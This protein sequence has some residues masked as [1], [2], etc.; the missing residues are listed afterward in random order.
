MTDSH[1]TMRDASF[2][3]QLLNE[4]EQGRPFSIATIMATRGSMPRHAPARMALLSDGSFIGTIGGGRIEQ[5]AQERL[6]RV[7]SGEEGS[8]YEWYTHAKTAM[9]CGGDALVSLRRSSENEADFLRDVLGR[10]ERGERFVLEEDWSD[11]ESPSLTLARVDELDENDPA[12][13]S[14][15]PLWDEKSARFTEPLGPDPIAYIFGGGHV[16]QALVPVLSSVGFRVVV[17][18]DREGIAVPEL[19]PQAER[20]ILGSFQDIG[21]KVKVTRRDYVVVLTHGHA[22]DIDV[23]EQVA[24]ARPAYVGCIGSKGK[25]AFARKTLIERGIDEK[26]VNECIHLPIGEK[27]LAVTPPEIAVSIAAEMIRCRA[28]LRPTKPHQH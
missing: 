23:L 4:V 10:L 20:V 16:G 5:M 22:G 13:T 26:W 2:V 14:E 15:E 19:F 27:I 3:R 28:E 21:A 25:A 7:L 9:A 6:G 1:E 24:P 8:A 12:A 11:P 17:F 18:D